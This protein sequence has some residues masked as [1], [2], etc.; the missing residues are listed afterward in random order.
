MKLRRVELC[1]FKSFVDRTVITFDQQV[2]AVVGPNGCGKSNILDAIRWAMGEQSARSLRGKSMEE[3]IFSGSES[4]PAS[5]VA[6]VSLVFDNSDGRCHPDFAEYGELAVTRELARDGTSDYKING[7]TCRLRDVTELLLS[8]GVSPRSSMVEQGRMGVIVTARPEER[9]LLIEEAAGIAK[10]RIHRRVTQRKMEQTRQNLLRITDVVAEMTRTLGS[11]KRQA[12]KARRFKEFR[13]ELTELELRAASHRYLELSAI[14]RRRDAQLRRAEVDLAAATEAAVGQEAAIAARRDEQRGAEERLEALQAS[15]YRCANLVQQ[16]RARIDKL[17][18]QLAAELKAEGEAEQTVAALERKRVDLVRELGETEQSHGTTADQVSNLQLE[19]D[20]RHGRLEAVR[21]GRREAEASL[22]RCRQQIAA[23][24]TTAA[25]GERALQSIEQRHAEGIER[26]QALQARQGEAERRVVE[27][28]SEVEVLS[29]VLVQ[30]RERAR[31]LGA[32]RESQEAERTRVRSEL[33]AATVELSRVGGE[34]T[35]CRSRLQSLEEIA[36]RY[37]NYGQGVRELMRKPDVR[38]RTRAVVAEVIDVPAGLEQALA[39]VLGE[40]LQDLVVDDLQAA[41]DVASVITATK[42]GRAAAVP[43]EPR[44]TAVEVVAPDGPGVVGML[45]DLIGF[46]PRHA[47]LVRQLV[48]SVAVVEDLTAALALWAVRGELTIVTRG[49]EVV[50]PSGRISAGQEELSLALLQTKREIKRLREKAT[51]LE[52]DHAQRATVVA[53]GKARLAELGASIEEI[54][55]TAHARELEVVQQQTDLARVEGELKRQRADVERLSQDVL[56]VSELVGRSLAERDRVSQ[57]VRDAERERARFEEELVEVQ[58]QLLARRGEE[59]EALAGATELRVQA[60]SA[61]ER[62]ESQASAISRL[63]RERDEVARQLDRGREDRI[64]AAG[65]QGSI[66]G[67]I[68]VER[69]QLDRL[70]ADETA[71]REAATRARD[72]LDLLRNDLARAEADAHGARRLLS[73]LRE[74]AEQLRLALHEARMELKSLLERV[75]DARDTDLELVVVDFHLMPPVTEEDLARIDELRR[76]IE[77]IGPVNLM[78]VEEHDELLVRFEEST[79]QKEDLEES[80]DHLQRAIQKLNREGRRRFQE[81]FDAVNEQFQ[82]FFPRL[83]EGGRAKL[84]LTDEQDLLETGVDIMAQPP[85]KKLGSMEL[86]SG[87]EKAMTAVSLIFALFMASPSPFT[88]L[89]EVD[90]PFDDAN[91]RRYL[92]VLR[93]MSRSSQFVLVTHSKL[94]MAE[95]DVLYGVT[96]EEPGV[97]KMVT[98]RFNDDKSAPEHEEAASAAAA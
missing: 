94:S 62:A 55:R 69:D 24:S 9:R 20:F 82:K 77:R 10:Y 37:E 46:E 16:A 21:E 45:V 75:K 27:L 41:S 83:F 29:G 72:A 40:R 39:A 93:E 13:D 60:A 78:A 36:G 86:M 49:G 50:S 5:S 25:A 84:V 88:I 71:A 92:G 95:A 2:T 61:R 15:S 64:R 47:A 35:N 31:D 43:L 66:G 23:A 59:E 89:D 11:L 81:C 73:E 4:R 8:A 42:L 96:M 58:R 19:L 51:V 32:S 48:G 17:T 22:E 6:E 79:K 76:Q 7:V 67:E 44:D 74:G 98:V 87:G 80:L 91:V 12:S 38:R 34:L 18:G 14:A 3:V 85:G 28:V 56:K 57:E 52:R 90:A 26:A 54:R 1:G 63:G 53:A 65:A 30:L 68:F 33:D 97:S 70:A